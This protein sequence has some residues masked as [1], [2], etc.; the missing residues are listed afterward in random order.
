MIFSTNDIFTCREQ[1]IYAATAARMNLV[2]LCLVLPVE[3]ALLVYDAWLAYIL[4]RVSEQ[5]SAVAWGGLRGHVFWAGVL[6]YLVSSFGCTSS[7]VLYV[8]QEETNA[9][10]VFLFLTLNASCIVF[11]YALVREMKNVV[12]V[13]LWTNIFCCTA[14][15]VNTAD[16]FDASSVTSAWSER[17][18]VATHACNLVGVVHVYVIDLLI[19]HSGWTDALAEKE[20]AQRECPSPPP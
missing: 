5:E 19:W 14:L 9:F 2:L 3:F 8:S 16:V 17:L 20:T 4:H 12:L 10:P 18:L 11:N 15:F 6:T 1:P 13:C 7:F